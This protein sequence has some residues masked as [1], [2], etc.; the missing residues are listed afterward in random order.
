MVHAFCHAVPGRWC[1]MA[2]LLNG[3]S[4]LAA[5]VRWTGGREIGAALSAVEQAFSG[6][7]DLLALPYLMGERTPHNDP[8]A[9]GAVIGMTSA[10][11]PSDLIQATLEGVA[12]SLADGFQALTA[13]GPAITV[14]GFIGGGARSLFWG[15]IIAAVLDVTL[16]RYDAA[17]RGPAFGAARLGR[18]CAT[19]EA[20]ADVVVP[21]PV[22]TLI[23]PDPRL[24][25][26]YRARL[27]R[28]R[29]LYAALKP[30][31]RCEA[32]DAAAVRRHGDS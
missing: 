32:D 7:S 17:E 13:A 10:T 16:V 6:P 4:P 11:R 24:T 9:R 26:L 8:F 2:A 29:A 1:R 12:F 21:P 31:F 5:V 20:M 18:L 25:D 3:A 27:A 28:F 22:E 19:G 30:V 14:F 15:R 23:L